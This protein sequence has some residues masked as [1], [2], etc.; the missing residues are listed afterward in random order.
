MGVLAVGV[1]KLEEALPFFKTALEANPN[2][3][4][5]WL[6]YIDALIKLDRIADAKAVFNQAKS[7][8]AKGDGF[9]K[10]QLQLNTSTIENKNWTKEDAVNQSNILDKLKLNQ[11]LKLAKNKVKDG[12]SDQAKQIYQDILKKFPKNKEAIDGIKK[13]DSKIVANTFDTGEPP[14]DQLQSLVN[15]YNQG[16]YQEALDLALQLQQYFSNSV[17]LYNIMGAANKGLGRLDKAVEAYTKAL[18]KARLC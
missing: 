5:Y 10:I 8:G 13:L 14:S 11:A 17:N 6:S 15:L 18:S 16:K 2:T 9:D 7:K 3:A 1:G 4:Q 12:L